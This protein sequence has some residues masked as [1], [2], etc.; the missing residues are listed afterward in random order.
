MVSVFSQALAMSLA[1]ICSKYPTSAGA[2]YWTFC[3]AAPRYKKLSS[4]INGWLTMVGVWTISLS[5][6][7]VSTL[8]TTP[9]TP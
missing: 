4:W 3:L 2:Y 1:E 7:F 6:N 5:V 9:R 8:S